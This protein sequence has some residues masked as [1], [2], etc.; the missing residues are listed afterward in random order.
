[1]EREASHDINPV[2]ALPSAALWRILQEKLMKTIK[3][4]PA[5]W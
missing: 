1:M 3:R 5:D 2:L 4:F